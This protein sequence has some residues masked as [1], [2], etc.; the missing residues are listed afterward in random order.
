MRTLL[1]PVT[2]GGFGT[3]VAGQ[4]RRPLS[5]LN[6]N[7][8]PPSQVTPTSVNPTRDWR[9]SVAASEGAAAQVRDS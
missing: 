1:A 9:A 5:G 6:A 7:P 4:A 2:T 8:A 3:V